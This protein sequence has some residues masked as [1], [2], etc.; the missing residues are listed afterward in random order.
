MVGP[1]GTGRDAIIPGTNKV[2]VIVD[3]ESSIT[4]LAAALTVRAGGGAYP[5]RD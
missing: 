4:G 3:N 5:R 1:G 2:R